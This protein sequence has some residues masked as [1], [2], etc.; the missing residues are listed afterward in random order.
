MRI[1][2]L[3]DDALQLELIQRA[4]AAMGHMCHTYQNGTTL[5]KALRRETFDLLIVDWEL[6]DIPGPEIVRW[7]REN[8]G[9]SYRSCSSR[10][11][12]RSATLSKGWAVART[13]SWSS[14]CAWVNSPRV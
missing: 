11:G 5:L 6:P 1:A 4:T 14:P 7:V 2:A 3:D 13:I 8:L 9:P 12:E 10:T